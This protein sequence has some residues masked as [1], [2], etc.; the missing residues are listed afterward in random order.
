MFGA[1]SFVDFLD[2]VDGLQT[3]YEHAEQAAIETSFHT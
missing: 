2:A 1:C 3:D